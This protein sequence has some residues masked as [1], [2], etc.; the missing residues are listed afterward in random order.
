MRLPVVKRANKTTF[1]IV[2]VDLADVF[3]TFVEGGVLRYQTEAG[4]FAQIS[5]LDEQE[6][7]LAENGFERIE[8][9]FIA[10]PAKA[11]FYD[12][13]LSVLHFGEVHQ[14]PVALSRKKVLKKRSA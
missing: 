2:Y 3:Y 6:R 7:F 5:T 12:D 9:G 8:R 4:V 11:T 13:E 10:Q 1:E 14:A